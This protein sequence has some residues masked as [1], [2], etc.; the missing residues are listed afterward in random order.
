MG[1]FLSLVLCFMTLVNHHI[2]T[3]SY[4]L[5]LPTGTLFNYVRIDFLHFNFVSKFELVRKMIFVYFYLP[6]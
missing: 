1:Q 6:Y 4:K 5:S 3:A 2:N